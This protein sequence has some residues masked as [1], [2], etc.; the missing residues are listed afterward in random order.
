MNKKE[1]RTEIPKSTTT[2]LLEI[3]SEEEFLKLMQ[4]AASDVLRLSLFL[5]DLN[6]NEKVFNKKLSHQIHFAKFLREKVVSIS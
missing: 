1:N 6:S 4:N 5:E 2:H 3:I